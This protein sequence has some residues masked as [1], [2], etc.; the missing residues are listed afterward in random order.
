MSRCVRVQRTATCHN[1]RLSPYLS[2]HIVKVMGAGSIGVW[3]GGGWEYRGGN[4]GGEV[5][6]W[7]GGWGGGGLV[8]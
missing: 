5:G 8:G 3:G 6:G 1:N 2:E 7:G 4:I